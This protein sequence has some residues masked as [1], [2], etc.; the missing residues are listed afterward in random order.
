MLE[1]RCMENA[2]G[3]K[4]LKSRFRRFKQFF[5]GFLPSK[6][7]LA[8]FIGF[9]IGGVLFAALDP[10]EAQ[11]TFYGG[12]LL[13]DLEAQFATP[14][15]LTL[16]YLVNQLLCFL[17]VTSWNIFFNNLV[18]S[19]V[20]LFSGFMIIPIILVNLFGFLGSVS[21]LLVLN[22]GIFKA[23]IRLLGSFHLIFELLAAML[24]IDAFFSFYGTIISSIRQKSISR[25]K[26]GTL[27][28]FLPMILRIVLLLI[29]AALLEVFWS[30]WW[31][32]VLNH[33]YISWTDFYTGVYSCVVP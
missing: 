4:K 17:G 23:S 27:N 21:Y 15:T 28:E 8:L 26:E 11:A 30:T 20:C 14:A 24:V 7:S 31:I 16:D 6:Y 32:Y 9:F 10:G 33:P 25:F 3:I 2:S 12:F 22:F 13:Y 5:R 18:V 19:M 29:L 1:G